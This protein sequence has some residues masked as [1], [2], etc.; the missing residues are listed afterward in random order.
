VNEAIR[1][2]GRAISTSIEEIE[3]VV[4]DLAGEVTADNAERYTRVQIYASRVIVALQSARVDVGT[5]ALAIADDGS[6]PPVG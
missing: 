6:T 2:R 4:R 5:L 1:A 3:Q